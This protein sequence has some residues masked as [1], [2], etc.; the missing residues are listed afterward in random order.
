[1]SGR[2]V[3][4]RIL[5]QCLEGKNTGG[6]VSDINDLGGVFRLRCLEETG[7]V[8]RGPDLN[9]GLGTLLGFS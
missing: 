1:M 5:C 9:P 8:E 6:K 4:M 2:H 3:G 7:I